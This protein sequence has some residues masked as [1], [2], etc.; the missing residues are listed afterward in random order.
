MVNGR[1]CSANPNLD[2]V[3][4]DL[5]IGM[6]MEEC[7]ILSLY[8]GQDITV[9]EAKNTVAYIEEKYPDVEVELLFGGQ[10]HYFYILGA[11]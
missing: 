3:L 4:D 10:P 9:A 11:E 7:E 8:Y 1:L 2:S 6:E 5:L